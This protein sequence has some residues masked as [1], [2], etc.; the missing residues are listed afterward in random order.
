M[1][2]LE[3]FL[4]FHFQTHWKTYSRNVTSLKTV[5][6]RTVNHLMLHETRCEDAFMR[7]QANSCV[8]P[9]FNKIA[10]FFGKQSNGGRVF[11]ENR[12]SISRIISLPSTSKPAHYL[13]IR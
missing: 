2:L 10:G 6:I 13:I 4:R 8:K 3:N 9:L 7:S 1:F 11:R 12:P 5:G